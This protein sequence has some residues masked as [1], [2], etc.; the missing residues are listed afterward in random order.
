M[1]EETGWP[2]GAIK[3]TCWLAG[4]SKESG[5]PTSAAKKS[6]WSAGTTEESR[7]PPAPPRRVAGRQVSLTRVAVAGWPLFQLGGHK[8]LVQSTYIHKIILWSK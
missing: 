4:A 1:A 8:H 5:W 6:G 2:A 7:W 3:Y